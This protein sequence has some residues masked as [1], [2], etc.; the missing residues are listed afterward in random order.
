LNADTV[1]SFLSPMPA[2]EFRRQHLE[3]AA[4]LM[5]RADH[6]FFSSIVSL[7]QLD[8]LVTSIRI[9]ATNLN[10]AQGDQPLALSA[11]CSGAGYV[12]KGK[13]LDLHRRG[14]TIILRSI[15]QWSA[16]L[17]RL[18]I[19]AEDFFHC[20]CQIN[21]YLT[22]PGEKST[23]PHWDTHD[24]MVLQIAGKKTWRLYDAARSLPLADERFA[25]GQ[26]HVSADYRNMLLEAGDTLYLPRGVIHEPIAETYSVHLSIGINHLRWHDVVAAALRLVA[27]EEGSWLRR[28]ALETDPAPRPASLEQLFDQ[29]RL[30]EICGL[31]HEN[32]RTVR[33][34]DLQ[35]QILKICAGF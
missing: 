33:A 20:E 6:G 22:P 29:A 34:R 4:L 30:A 16:D 27:E 23:P 17:N 15:E 25:I 18:R 2:D 11:Y 24:L 28:A 21:V 19:E 31:L 12:D 13:M 10:L 1:P 8:E 7:E 32:A 26:D 9:P 35:G 3:R 5:Q 14:A